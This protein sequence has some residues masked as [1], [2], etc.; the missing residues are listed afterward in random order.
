MKSEAR[1]DPASLSHVYPVPSKIKT[2]ETKNW[3]TYPA[4][5]P[6]GHVDDLAVGVHHL[7]AAA[8]AG[9][10]RGVVAAAQ[11]LRDGS[12]DS[13]QLDVQPA[14]YLLTPDRG[15]SEKIVF[16]SP[17]KRMDLCFMHHSW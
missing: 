13:H 12:A 14:G 11:T 3:G 16:D 5:E 8:L 17:S 7:V 10:L 15:E 2:F 4:G 6:L 9:V 1:V